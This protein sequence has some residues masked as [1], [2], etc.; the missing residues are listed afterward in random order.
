MYIAFDPFSLLDRKFV[1]C[2][3]LD[4]QNASERLVSMSINDAVTGSNIHV[5]D[6]YHP[7]LPPTKN[8]A[9]VLLF[10]QRKHEHEDKDKNIHFLIDEFNQE[11]LTTKYSTQLNKTLQQSF[12]ESTVVIALQS[13]GKSRTIQTADKQNKF[14]TEVM[15]VTTSGMKTFQLGTCA[16]MSYQLHQLQRNLETEIENNDFEAPLTFK[17]KTLF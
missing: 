4:Q 5:K 12:K 13:V 2:C 6:L 17:G 10:L 9:D 16:R 7:T 8:I 14:Q 11:L 3:G 15:D 1:V